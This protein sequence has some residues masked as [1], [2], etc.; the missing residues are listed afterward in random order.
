MNT[1][2]EPRQLARKPVPTPS[3]NTQL[4]LQ[5]QSQSIKALVQAHD[6]YGG[7]EPSLAQQV[8]ADAH[9][10]GRAMQAEAKAL[11]LKP[12]PSTAAAAAAAF[13]R[14]TWLAARGLGALGLGCGIAVLSGVSA[15]F[16]LF[17][18][19][20]ALDKAGDTVCASGITSL[21]RSVA[22]TYDGVLLK[23]QRQYDRAYAKAFAL[24]PELADAVREAAIQ[25]PQ[26]MPPQ[27]LATPPAQPGRVAADDWLGL[28]DDAPLPMARSASVAS[29]V[30][31]LGS[32]RTGQSRMSDV[33]A[34]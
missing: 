4:A 29:S 3:H 20:W 14:R 21:K 16:G 26:A 18:L 9:Q 8:L 34:L 12:R 2:N 32:T 24:A 30:S 22:T 1:I 11:A 17:P 31:S 6:R 13:G 27:A 28:A 19:V 10:A 15:L 23:R 33:S 5:K 25:Q 7:I